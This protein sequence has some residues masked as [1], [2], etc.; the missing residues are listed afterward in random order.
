ME[1]KLLATSVDMPP[2]SG[3]N[4]QST[5][6]VPTSGLALATRTS[7]WNDTAYPE[8]DFVWSASAGSDGSFTF[9]AVPQK[10]SGNSDASTQRPSFPSAQISFSDWCTRTAVA[11]YA[12]HASMPTPMRSQLINLY[13]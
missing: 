5:S 1:I 10:N 13:A 2:I 4:S 11:Q 9:Y 8:D 12:L 3:E 6:L 7:T